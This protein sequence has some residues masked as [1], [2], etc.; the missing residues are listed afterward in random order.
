MK[1]GS[2]DI[3][4]GP[5]PKPHTATTKPPAAFAAAAMIQEITLIVKA[6]EP[7]QDTLQ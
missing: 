7:H 1:Y 2:T 3:T 5:S 4:T 6:S